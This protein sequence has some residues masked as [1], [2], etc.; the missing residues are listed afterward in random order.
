MREHEL[1]CYQYVNRPYAK[2]KEILTNDP[3][4]FFQRATSAAATRAQDLVV[5]LKVTVAGHE[6]D[7]DVRIEVTSIDLSGLLDDV[8]RRLEADAA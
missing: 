5:K 1:R 2:V 6:V 8:V 3:L 4:H 7:R